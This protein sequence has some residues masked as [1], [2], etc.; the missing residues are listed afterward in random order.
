MILETLEDRV[1][2][3]ATPVVTLDTPDPKIGEDAQIT[4]NF[5]NTDA[6]QE[7][8]GPFIDLAIDA[9]GEDG[10]YNKTTNV[11]DQVADGLSV[12]ASGKVKYLGSN[13]NYQ[14]LT[15]DDDTNN[16]GDT[17][18]ATDGVLH[19]YAKDSSGNSIY[20]KTSDAWLGGKFQNG[21]KIIV[22]ELPFGSFAADQPVAAITID[23]T[24]SNLADVSTALEVKARGGFRY[25]NDP[26]DN[27][28]SDATIFGAASAGA[29]D[30]IVPTLFTVSKV[31]NGPENETATGP[32]F[33]RRY[34]INADIANGQTL[35]SLNL[36][37]VLPGLAGDGIVDAM[38]FVSFTGSTHAYTAV[39]TPSTTS[40]GGT[41]QIQFDS[42]ITGTTA[43][44]DAW[45][46]FS[47]FVPRID[48]DSNAVLNATTG[49]FNNHFNEAYGYGTW[50]PT[51]TRDGEIWTA[52]QATVQFTDASVAGGHSASPG[53]VTLDGDH[54]HTL[55]AQSIA[56]QKSVS[57]ITTGNTTYHV[58]D[59]LEYTLDFQ[60]SDYFAFNN[61]VVTDWF[62]DGLRLD[63]TFAPTLNVTSHGS[64]LGV[65]SFTGA[66]ATGAFAGTNWAQALIGDGTDNNND[67]VL[68]GGRQLTFDISNELIRRAWSGDGIAGADGML[69]GGGVGGTLDTTDYNN[70]LVAPGALPFGAT[71]GQLKFR[72]VI[73][74]A[75][76]EDYPSGEAPVN[77][78]DVLTNAVEITGQ[79]LDNDTLAGTGNTPIDD[80]GANVTITAG[81]LTKSIYAVNGSTSLPI[82]GGTVQV[83]P[84]DTVTYRI[85][86]TMPTGDVENLA[87][88][89]YL[90]MPVY[91]AGDPN[92]DGAVGGVGE[93]VYDGAWAA[94]APAT[95][96][97]VL[98]PSDTFT[99]IS[100]LTPAVTAVSTTNNSVQFYSAGDYDYGPNT[101][102]TADFM[103]TV[104]VDD[105][106]F[107]DG[108]YLT[109]QVRSEEQN[110]QSPGIKQ[111]A[112]SIIQVVINEPD[113]EIYKGI[114]ASEK[115]GVIAAGTLG[116]LTFGGVGTTTGFTAGKMDSVADVTTF[117]ASNLTSGTLPDAGDKVRFALIVGNTGRSD[118]FDVT[119]EDTILSQ[120]ADP[121]ALTANQFITAT[122]LVVQ[123]GDQTTALVHGVDFN[124]TWDDGSNTFQIELVDSYADADGGESKQGGLNRGL[125]Q[126]GTERTDGFNFVIVSYDLTL[127]AGASP[128]YFTA[129]TPTDAYIRNTASLTKYAGREGGYDHLQVNKTEVAD[130]NTANY[131]ATKTIVA[132]SET[133]TTSVGGVTTALVGEVIR[134]RIKVEIPEGQTY[135]LII[136]DNLPAGLIFLNDGT[137]KV[138]F[139]SS[140][141]NSISSANPTGD[142]LGLGLGTGAPLWQT[143]NETTVD[144]IVLGTVLADANIGSSTSV[145]V[146][147]DTYA[148][149]TD[150]QFKLGNILNA[151]SDAD[152]EYVVIEFNALVEN[153]STNQAG[154]QLVN[155]V[156]IR[157][158]TANDVMVSAKGSVTAV[159]VEPQITN[160]KTQITSAQPTD[161]GDTFTYTITFSNHPVIDS[162]AVPVVQAATTSALSGATYTAGG[163]VSL[164]GEF[165]GVARTIDGISLNA[166][167]RVL[168]A[169]QADAKQNGVYRV[170]YVDAQTDTVVLDRAPDNNSDV[171]VTQ[172]HRIAV[173]G[174]TTHNGKMFWQETPSVTL[175][176]SNVVYTEIQTSSAVNWATTAALAG[177][178][179]TAGTG[180]WTNVA[181]S[182]DGVNNLV[183]GNR[184]LVKNETT[185]NSGRQGIFRVS[186]VGATATLVRVD[187]FNEDT[188]PDGELPLGY[189]VFVTAG[190]SNANKSYGLRATVGAVDAGTNPDRVFWQQI[191][192]PPAYNITVIDTLP[193]GM[194]LVSVD[195]SVAGGN[196]PTG[197][198]ETART[199]TVGAGGSF[200][201]TF[202][203][204]PESSTLSGVTNVT[205]TVNAKIGDAA[206]S[207]DILSNNVVVN[208]TSLPGDSGTVGGS[209]TTGSNAPGVAGAAD[210]E[211]DGSGVTATDNTFPVYSTGLN[212]YESG[213][214][215]C[216]QV[217]APSVDKRFQGGSISNDDTSES[218]TT[219]ANV[220]VGETVNYDI[221]VTLAEGTTN[222]LTVRDLL[223]SGLRINTAYNGGLGYELITT[224]AASGGQLAANLGVA[225]G[226]PTVTAY[227]AGVLGNDGVDM[228]LAFGNITLAAD[229]ATNNNSFIIRVQAITTDVVGNQSG[230]TLE[231][232]AAVAYTNPDTG[233][234]VAIPDSTPANDPIVTVREPA[235]TI[236]KTADAAAADAGDDVTY[237]ITVTNSSAYYA[238]DISLADTLDAVLTGP[239]IL[240]GAGDFTSSGT[241]DIT[242]GDGT[243]G[244]DDFVFTGQAL[245]LVAGRDVDMASG[246]SFVLKVKG[247]LANT[248]ASGQSITNTA[249]STWTSL[250]F[251]QANDG[252]DADERTGADG[253]AGALNDYAVSSS[254][255]TTA[256]SS[257]TLTKI[258]ASSD[259]PFTSGSNAA[260]GETFTYTLT[261]TLAEGVTNNL[262]ITDM[263]QDDANGVLQIVSA[264][265]AS[266][267]A[268]LSGGNITAGTMI[269][270][271]A[272][273]LSNAGG[274][275]YNDRATF[276]FGNIT[277]T[278]DNVVD[279]ND[280]V[281]FTVTA[282]VVNVTAN[283]SGDVL[284]NTA[285]ATYAAGTTVDSAACNVTVVEPVLQ[286][287]KA[288]GA[289]P[290]LDAGDTVT[291]TITVSHAAGSGQ[292]AYDIL[293]NDTLP[294]GQLENFALVSAT[295]TDGV[296]G[297]A[298]SD[299]AGML[300]LA[301]NV[302]STVGKVYLLRDTGGAS[303]HEQLVVV[304]RGDVKDATVVG[305]TIS[306]TATA[307]WSGLNG[308]KDGDDAGDASERTGSDGAADPNNYTVT[309]TATIPTQ[310]ALSVSKVVDVP[311][312]TIGD[313]VTYT[314]TVSVAEGRTVVNLADTLPAGLQ[315]VANSVAVASNPAAMVIAGLNN[316]SLSQTLTITNAGASNG[317]VNAA[318]A[319]ET[320]SF[321]ITYQAKV[322]D[323]AGNDG[324]TA[325]GDGNGQTSLVNDVDSSADLNNDGDIL[326]A[327]ETDNN[328]TATVTVVEPLL[329]I[330]KAHNDGDGVVNAN[331]T[332]TY[333]L[334]I[335]NLG[336][337]GSTAA[338]YDIRVRDA[339]PATLTNLTFNPANVVGAN[340][341]H[342]ATAGGTLDITLDTLALGNTATISFTADVIAG[343]GVNVNID[344]NAKIY[345]DNRATDEGSTPGTGNTVKGDAD[346]ASGDRD[347]GA[348]ADA[349]PGAG[350]DEVHDN[351]TDKAQD[352]VRVTSVPAVNNIGGF[353]Y[354]DADNDGVKDAGEAVLVGV[355]VTLTGTD[356]GG[357]PVSMTTTTAA[358][359]SYAFSGFP[360]SNVAGYTL[361][362]TQ[363][364]GYLDG[365]ETVGTTFGGTA[366][367]TIVN[368]TITSIVIPAG[369]N[370]GANYNFGELLASSV[371]GFVYVD[372]DS[373]GVKDAGESAISGVAVRL[374]GTDD[375]GAAVNTA[376]NTAADG[377][378]SFTSLR[379]GTYTLTE[380]QPNTY[381]DGKETAGTLFGGTVNNTAESQTISTLSIG[382]N[383]AG[384]NYNFG[385]L[386]SS[387][388]AGFVYV[389]ANNNGAK[390]GGETG[391]SNTTVKLT[392]TDDRG[393]NVSVTATT[394]ASGAFLFSD[395]RPGTY[396]LAET[397]PSAYQ[398]GTDAVGS[399][400][401]STGNDL[402]SSVLLAA[403]TH[404]TNYLFG[405]KVKATTSSPEPTYTSL[406][407]T[408]AEALKTT[409]P[410]AS[411][412]STTKDT[413]GKTRDLPQ[414]PF[415]YYREPMNP[416]ASPLLPLMPIYSGRAEPGATLVVTL[417]GAKGEIVGMQSVVSDVGGNWLATMPN[418]IISDYPRS[419][420][421]TQQSATYSASTD[422]AT[423]L[424]AYFA[425]AIQAGEFFYRDFDIQSIFSKR[426]ASTV[427]LLCKS[428]REPN[429]FGWGSEV[430]DFM[431]A[432]GTPA[433][434]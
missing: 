417:Y 348:V 413:P 412:T 396:S 411:S 45:V 278:S 333:T 271:T 220:L 49:A 166:G 126:D 39:S 64:T 73:Q 254:V 63:T 128:N 196:I 5:D 79:V 350:T 188:A 117:S 213:A 172:Y 245:S 26:L 198:T 250:D 3:S 399:A 121:G 33:E 93:W 6:A 242:G 35:T 336:A 130:V 324:I 98:G 185:A 247:T 20:L 310:G 66:S 295:V 327:G 359:G 351:D 151:D 60:V 167:D 368:Q 235:L 189:E 326:D 349:D 335:T 94:G 183:V 314:V 50:D 313:T 91:K 253:V 288:I 175:N 224:A 102:L 420:Q 262:V 209:N 88:T 77:P 400:G 347:Y 109:N 143:G 44:V 299:V 352:T 284:A 354:V 30:D 380:T 127:A 10:V 431:A 266:I 225:L 428:M 433:G 302:L 59:T 57:N 78:R 71:T 252:S 95:G 263:A 80:S 164:N 37:D 223:P 425:P 138:A 136:D 319:T 415:A 280:R 304:V 389:D 241:I 31:Y 74:N 144:A 195:A 40:P 294:N 205:V 259:Q 190:A 186:A 222:A 207:G 274:S 137:T 158:N 387:S 153:V 192:M 58:G 385:E 251:D 23:A 383:Q 36:A 403:N 99:A 17:V 374:T 29:S 210:G 69:L 122:G 180:T 381:F 61:I 157:A 19:P 43:T 202:D 201:L 184:V 231:N 395:L 112:D 325:A 234:T 55:E 27:P 328:N 96:H 68:E 21:D 148:S 84:G 100:G 372:T 390:D 329:V 367:N 191:E 230:T 285:R 366:N 286:I 322:L 12:G 159:V 81:V 62:S 421:I 173:A 238:Y 215:L 332:I 154:V 293:L 337:N 330:T 97:V 308:A 34:R 379:P 361:T 227:G 258:V 303:T 261:V 116:G 208:Y 47:F 131:T 32:N 339:L 217:G 22:I 405:E 392:G 378:Y 418:S 371:S 353:V 281:T 414:T 48:A 305:T 214:Q 269:V 113:V 243:I 229:G 394:D 398:D 423:G 110:T 406:R 296:G 300:N 273:T 338:A 346:G 363:P 14:I 197:V 194:E 409:E 206:V 342:K 264:Q 163:G 360:Q 424:R 358:D 24:M 118:A 432:Q 41:L 106:P 179:Y 120:Y 297:N 171:E 114:V 107:A 434:Y 139:V 270:G 386:Q 321:T 182:I 416:H 67:V 272:G 150:P 257:P 149:S 203:R 276:T 237:T 7:G 356:I 132:T 267:G 341:T 75:F 376:A 152:K 233:G 287:N 2:Y 218:T 141:L 108:M 9:T 260:V 249:T 365:K 317:T 369:S 124:L 248:V 221:L 283:Q 301:G 275:A 13:V 140:S 177:A 401:G 429:Y 133:D 311:T 82:V 334:T 89:D 169:G 104:T 200:S 277:N 168:V 232:Q 46:E 1:L 404:G 176:T 236:T 162:N 160:V 228:Q 268:N 373:D 282:K 375:L 87:F 72:V 426:S 146:N 318:G 212:N 256:V 54:E 298:D 92:T 422:N 18:D 323:V 370:T 290:G 134:Y 181:L 111:V 407:N 38:Q 170:F 240:N 155:T 65:G 42:A 391:I 115:A 161:G 402:L 289:A 135:N 219:G 105:D 355:T 16:D 382:S 393:G 364:G 211:R 357:G 388:L 291:Y 178:T 193:S 343:I 76:D 56:I 123:R 8:Y 419:V 25:G 85:T 430:A 187:D 315:L 52:D 246:A 307:K 408:I 165:T 340:V 265:V 362:E 147:T 199:V 125:N 86:Y 244:A 53:T 145:T 174:G 4:V 101:L 255:V 103:F 11:W 119:F 279:A 320:D 384:A 292:N 306:N 427:L 51:D 377:S 216:V 344:N 90:P 204:L 129:Q 312:A 226:A 83:T 70:P 28:T 331:Q 156:D 142:T 309:S 316:N 15:L 345:Y 239:T 410:T 397:Q